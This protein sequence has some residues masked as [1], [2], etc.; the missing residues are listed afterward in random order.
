MGAMMVAKTKTSV[1]TARV[2]SATSVTNLFSNTF[3]C[4]FDLV[5]DNIVDPKIALRS[6]WIWTTMP[7]EEVET[8]DDYPRIVISMVDLGDM[9]NISL[10]QKTA[11]PYLYV[12]I[13]STNKSEVDTLSD[14]LIKTLNNNKSSLGS[15]NLE[16][17]TVSCVVSSYER[18]KFTVYSRSFRLEF[19]VEG[20]V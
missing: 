18:S 19:K 16:N 1:G 17:F 4:I 13:Y 3:R 5:N 15:D 6:K 14:Q 11:R 7:E 12:F 2:G 10:C 9:G 20:I 8:K